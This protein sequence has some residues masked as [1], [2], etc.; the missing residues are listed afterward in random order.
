M[1]SGLIQPTLGI[2]GGAGPMAGVLLLQKIIQICQEKYHCQEDDDFPYIV[3]LSYPFTDSLISEDNANLAKRQLTTCLKRLDEDGVKIVAIACNTL[4][5]YLDGSAYNFQFVHM[6][7]ET[8]KVIHLHPVTESFVLC[9]MTAA[10]CK[11]HQKYFNCIYPDEDLQLEIYKLMNKILAGNHCRE[12]S[13]QLA[14]QLN[15]QLALIENKD[16][17]V[18]LVLGCTEFSVLNNQFPLHLHGI[19]KRF[20]IFDPNQIVAE[21]ICE[22][23]F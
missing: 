16:N 18:G 19:D 7:Q 1:Q 6:I 17:N 4:H 15:A 2:I 13:I 20:T 23:I 11:L 10:R 3:L 12:D 22:L 8:A 5:E 14:A 9:S 21:K